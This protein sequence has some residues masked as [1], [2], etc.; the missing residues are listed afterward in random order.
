[1]RRQRIEPDVRLLDAG[2]ASLAAGVPP[3][4]PGTL[5]FR[6]AA[7]GIVVAPHR[8]FTVVF[9]RDE[10]NVHVAVG[11]GD[12][13]MSREHGRVRRED[14]RWILTND[15]RLPLQLPGSVHLL[16]G[17]S[18][19]VAPGYTPITVKHRHGPLHVIEAFVVPAATGSPHSV[20]NADSTSTGEPWSLQPTERLALIVLARRYLRHERF[21]QPL[22]WGQAAEDLVTV[23]GDATWNARRVERLVEKV[24][25]R[26]SAEGVPGLTREEVGE[27]VGNALNHNLITELLLSTTLVPPDLTEIAVLDW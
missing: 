23:T 7:G 17:G 16:K 20:G 24:R 9:G 13:F 26:L 6:S 14:G 25:R 21:A 2:G 11:V 22:A 4:A 27:P 12:R 8:D 19:R 5:Y 1:M 3:S 10:P 18:T 15:G